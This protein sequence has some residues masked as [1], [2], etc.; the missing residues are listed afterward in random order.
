MK[1]IALLRG[2]NVGGN[3]KVDM[4][5]LASVCKSLGLQNVK[6]YINSGNILFDSQLDP[7]R[8]TTLL[9]NGIKKEFA[10][11]VPVIIVS[12][13]KV[14][15]IVKKV[16]SSWTNDTEMK[17]DV[18]FLWDEVNDN[19][20]LEKFNIKSEIDNV[21]YVDGAVVWNIERK[22]VTRSGLLKIIGTPLYKKMTIR[23]INTV[24]KLKDLAGMT[25]NEKR[26]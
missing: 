14:Q 9:E 7:G 1:Y 22:N 19:S 20:I 24:R 15:D 2:I 13:N 11:S 10:L 16:P 4:K 12:A 23:N 21:M 5:L 18:M 8:I 6:T 17:T 26:G 3:S 25:K